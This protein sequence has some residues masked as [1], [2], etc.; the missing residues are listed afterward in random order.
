MGMIALVVWRTAPPSRTVPMWQVLSPVPLVPETVR[1][2]DE[3]PSAAPD[4]T[5]T[6]ETRDAPI[7]DGP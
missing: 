1:P 2:S 7:M 3:P 6:P 4:A 5:L